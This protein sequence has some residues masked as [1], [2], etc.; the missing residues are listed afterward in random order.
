MS[1]GDPLADNSEDVAAAVDRAR[2]AALDAGVPIGRIRN[3]VA[4]AQAAVDAGYRIVRIGSDTGAIRE[5]LGAR[6]D[7]LR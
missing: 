7:G 2:E 3:S 6:L 1:G 5:T 4:E